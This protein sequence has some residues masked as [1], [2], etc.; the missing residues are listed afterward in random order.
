MP[1]FRFARPRFNGPAHQQSSSL[2]A[3]ASLDFP[4]VAALGSATLTVPCT[5]AVVGDDV[6]VHLDAPVAGLCYVAW[7][8]A[9]DVVT[10]RATNITAAPIDAPA[11]VHRVRVWRA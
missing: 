9:A 4:S 5:G 11:A 8:S 3:K 6:T 2:Q 10:V 7:V 1:S